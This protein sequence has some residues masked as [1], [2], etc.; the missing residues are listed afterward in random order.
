[1]L[2]TVLCRCQLNLKTFYKGPTHSH[3]IA[4]LSVEKESSYAPSSPSNS[5][6]G[7]VGRLYPVGGLIAQV[8]SLYFTF[9]ISKMGISV[10]LASSTPLI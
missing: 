7:C 3:L 10:T 6:V 4:E 2:E 1:M 9:P 8:T 5:K